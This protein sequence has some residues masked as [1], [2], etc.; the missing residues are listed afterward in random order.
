MEILI[1]NRIKNNK[2]KEL[3]NKIFNENIFIKWLITYLNLNNEN[4]YEL[5]GRCIYVIKN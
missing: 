5:Y 4:N 2:E 1:N 3:F